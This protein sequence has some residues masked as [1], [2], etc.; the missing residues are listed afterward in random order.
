[1]KAESCFRESGTNACDL[2]LFFP[3]QSVTLNPMVEY[4]YIGTG[5]LILF[6]IALILGKARKEHSDYI[7]VLWLVIFLVNVISLTTIMK[8]GYPGSLP[9]RI[10]IEFSEAS[11]FIHGPL[12]WFYT[13]SLTEPGFQY[14]KQYLLHFLPFGMSY[15]LLL[16]LI[17][18]DYT[19]LSWQREFLFV[20]KMGSLILYAIAALRR[21]FKHHQTVENIFSN[22]EDK[23]LKW[24]SILGYGILVAAAVASGSFI[25]GQ[26]SL[27]SFSGAGTLYANVAV[28]AFIYV[29]GYFGV[30][31]NAIF[32]LEMMRHP[33]NKTVYYD[34]ALQQSEPAMAP[35]YKKSGLSEEKA[36]LIY[37]ELI[38]LM[39]EREPY[40]DKDLTLMN[41]AAALNTN[42]NYLSQVI[43]VFEN[44]NFFEFINS[45]RVRKVQ[46]AILS[47]KFDHLNLLGIAL[48][49]GFNSKASFNRAFKKI[50]GQTPSEFRKSG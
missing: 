41:L 30:R 10:L 48:D 33:L 13:L 11:V 26:L 4:L 19:A 29:M 40:L 37:N 42:P 38:A 24:L 9:G 18:L 2:I 47:N 16:V 34:E 15:V 1:M 14:R 31:Q 43:N 28:C 22:L 12:F 6:M 36:E 8:F 45:Y 21:L 5:S 27:I 39:T 25:A 20:I 49:C 35:R 23:R 50:T 17:F 44:Q 32:D 46:Q 3:L 7:F